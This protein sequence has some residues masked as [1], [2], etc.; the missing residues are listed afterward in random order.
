MKPIAE[1]NSRLIDSVI[2]EE[3]FNLVPGID[4][5]PPSEW[6]E[7]DLYLSDNEGG[8][9]LLH[10]SKDVRHDVAKAYSSDMNQTIKLIE[11]VK[12][13]VGVSIMMETFERGSHSATVMNK[14]DPDDNTMIISTTM[15]SAVCLVILDFYGVD[16][17]EEVLSEKRL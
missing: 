5:L 7:Y 4:F 14:D 2:A 11:K 8:E 16:L 12:E 15:S 3:I 10:R 17:Y 6:T 13:D 1:I 9:Y